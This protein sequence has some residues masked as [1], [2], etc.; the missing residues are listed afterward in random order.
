MAGIAGGILFGLCW[1]WVAWLTGSIRWVVVSRILV[2]V[3]FLSVVS[4]VGGS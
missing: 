2:N 4:F 3:G 1:G